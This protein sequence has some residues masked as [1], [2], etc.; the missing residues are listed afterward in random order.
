VETPLAGSF[1][2]RNCLAVIAAADHVGADPEGVRTGLR[3]FRS[4]RRRMEVRGEVRGVTV[5]D[6]F[7][8]HPTAVRE[9]LQAARQRYS[10]RRIVAV[11]E[12]R[13]YTAQRREFQAAYQA[14]FDYADSIIIAGLFHPERYDAST[15]MDPDEMVA[16]WRSEGKEA[17]YIPHVDDIV[18]HLCE[19]LAGGE[20]VMIMSNGGFGGIH[21]KLLDGLDCEV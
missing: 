21:D 4:V 20:V 10:D 3:T 9:T 15:A 18:D 12:P 14:A 7:A 5:I 16:G 2:I 1:S 17:H 8:H 6:D 11:F 19:A 13:S